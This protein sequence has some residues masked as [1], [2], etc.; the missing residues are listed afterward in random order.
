[1]ALTSLLAQLRA[2][3]HDGDSGPRGRNDLLWGYTI[4]L[5]CE[6][7]NPEVAHETVTIKQ[8][9][10]VYSPARSLVGGV[11][12]R[13]MQD[14]KAQ[15]PEEEKSV[16]ST[17]NWADLRAQADKLGITL[18]QLQ[19]QQFEKKMRL[20]RKARPYTPPAKGGHVDKPEPS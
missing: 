18:S 20:A 2:Q 3:K 14:K 4:D 19:Q 17:T 15:Q 6:S 12:L 1:M 5:F 16:E 11:R 13:F 8:V 7:R 9:T 10:K